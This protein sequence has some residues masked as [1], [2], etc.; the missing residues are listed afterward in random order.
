M[1]SPHFVTDLSH[2][3]ASHAGPYGTIVSSWKR[4]GASIE[5]TITIPA[6]SGATV[7]FDGIA[8]QH[9]Y[10]DKKQVSLKTTLEAGTYQFV[11]K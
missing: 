9:V 2:F 1:L 7:V 8:G 6:N 3:T 5:Y 11:V 4:V 10:L